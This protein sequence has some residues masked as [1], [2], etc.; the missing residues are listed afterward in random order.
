MRQG[1]FMLLGLFTN[2]HDEAKKM[3]DVLSVPGL[4]AGRTGMQTQA[5]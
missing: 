5:P 3:R 2:D 1:P 4:E